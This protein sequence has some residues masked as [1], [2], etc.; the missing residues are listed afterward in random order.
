MSCPHQQSFDV[1]DD[2]CLILPCHLR[3]ETLLL[4]LLCLLACQAE[5]FRYGM[6]FSEQEFANAG[7]LCCDAAQVG[8]HIDISVWLPQHSNAR[9]CVCTALY[10]VHHGGDH[11]RVVCL[12]CPHNTGKRMRRYK[13]LFQVE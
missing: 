3:C 12:A 6:A 8:L 5:S 9:L 13:T 2:Q 4:E 1:G 10:L 7:H 11:V